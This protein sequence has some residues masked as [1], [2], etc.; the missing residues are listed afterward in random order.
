MEGR[1]KCGKVNCDQHELLCRQAG[2]RAYPTVKFFAGAKRGKQ[3]VRC[4]W[5]SL[6][7]YDS[8]NSHWSQWHSY[9]LAIVPHLITLSRR[10]CHREGRG[11][12]LLMWEE[13]E[14]RSRRRG[15]D[16]KP[17]MMLTSMRKIRSFTLSSS[18]SPLVRSHPNASENSTAGNILH[19]KREKAFYF[20][21]FRFQ[22]IY[23]MELDHDTK[24]LLNYLNKRVPKKVRTNIFMMRFSK[25]LH[26]EEKTEIRTEKICLVLLIC[27]K[28]D[29][30]NF[31]HSEHSSISTSQRMSSPRL[32]ERLPVMRRQSCFCQNRSLPMCCVVK[33]EI[34]L[35][36]VFILFVLTA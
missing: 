2:V 17:K 18:L 12:I 20:L 24:S 26:S 15:S 1:V 7:L 16:E 23:G 14:K 9:S 10:G 29:T 22:S 13:R 25:L 8:Q 34:Y 6:F 35:L 19:S 27:R 28:L 32:Q 33:G 11:S 3:Q 5:H 36:H 30:T 4:W 21:F 31:E